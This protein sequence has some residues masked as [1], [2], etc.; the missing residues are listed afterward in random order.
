MGIMTAEEKYPAWLHYSTR[1][2]ISDLGGTD[3]P[4]SIIAQ[5]SA[6]ILDRKSVV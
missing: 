3:P 4:N 1:Q 6:T 2:E 5:P